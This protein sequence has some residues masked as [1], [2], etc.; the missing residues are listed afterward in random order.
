MVEQ[1]LLLLVVHPERPELLA[2][3][4]HLPLRASR[5]LQV[6]QAVADQVLLALHPVQVVLVVLQVLQ[7]YQVKVAL[8]LHQVHLVYQA[9][10]EQ[11]VLQVLLV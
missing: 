5:V 1:V 4:L 7:V 3:Q 2:L 6:L 9:H 8:Q 11:V 10:Q